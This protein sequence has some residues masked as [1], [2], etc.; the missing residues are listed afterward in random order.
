VLQLF[1]ETIQRD[2][3]QRAGFRFGA[4]G[5]HTSRTLMLDELT[6]LLA[7]VPAEADRAQYA[8]AIVD[9]NSLKVRLV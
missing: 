7:V 4:R 5:V 9:S 2:Q 3:A 8:F 6:A 1:G